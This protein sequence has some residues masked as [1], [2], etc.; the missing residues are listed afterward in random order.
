MTAGIRALESIITILLRIG[1]QIAWVLI[2]LMVVVTLLQVILRYGFNA[3]LPWPDEAARF[4]MLW[5]TGLIAPSAYRW[6]GFVSIDMIQDF[7]GKRAGAILNLAILI[8]S[9]AVLVIAL[10][11][12]QDH[13]RRGWRFNSGSMKIPLGLFGGEDIRMK[14]AWMYMSVYVGWVLMTLVNIEM[15]LKNIHTMIDPNAPWGEVPDQMALSV[16]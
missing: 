3:A 10:D 15:I 5:M 16:E 1:R 13:I 2:A 7:L 6:G 4:F 12:G 8:V 14:L 11:L 9:L